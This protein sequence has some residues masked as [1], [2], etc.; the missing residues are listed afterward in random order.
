[1]KSVVRASV[2]L[3]LMSGLWSTAV[4]ARCN[5][6]SCKP[7]KP[8]GAQSCVNVADNCVPCDRGNVCG[9]NTCKS[10]CG[11]KLP[12]CIDLGG[13]NVRIRGGQIYAWQGFP[14]ACATP[15]QAA[16]VIEKLAPATVVVGD[17]FSY[18]VQITNRGKNALSS[19]A[20]TDVLPE[21]FVFQSVSPSVPVVDGKL[22]L[23][24]GELPGNSAQQFTVTGSA[25]VTGCLVF[26]GEAQATFAF[27]IALP[28]TVTQ[29]A[30]EV[31][32][33]A[34]DCIDLCDT[35]SAVVCVKNPGTAIT[36][37]NCVTVNLPAG[38]TTARGESQVVF[39]AG[40]LKPGESKSFNL[41]DLRASAG[42]DFALTATATNSRGLLAGSVAVVK[43][44]QPI[45]AVTKGATAKVFLDKKILYEITVTNVGD[46][47]AKDVVLCDAF[48][49]DSANV[50]LGDFNPR[51]TVA[52][53]GKNMTWNIGS[54]QPGESRVFQY[55]VTATE[56]GVVRNTATVVAYCA[57]PRM[58]VAHT[59]VEGLPGLNTCVTSD[60]DPASLGEVVTYTIETK[61][62]GR[63]PNTNLV[64]EVILD[65]GMEFVD[66]T[67]PRQTSYTTDGAR[68]I[69]FDAL[70]NLG[71]NQTERWTVRVKALT[72]GDKRFITR[73]STDQ[74]KKENGGSGLPLIVEAAGTFYDPTPVMASAQ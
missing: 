50:R 71:N 21:G 62:Q 26:A 66:A 57:E 59:P 60:N 28:V 33:T 12:K 37:E 10:D 70:P 29:P 18:T 65:E 58:A 42:G 11:V 55:N 52:R 45:L 51:A 67:G 19:V 47:V 61:N 69:V 41:R 48:D 46:T 8:C 36:Y 3:L 68:T 16:V 72:T 38:I 34:P 24:I 40:T 32:I 35:L 9:Q 43:V 31:L 13:P 4:W 44:R 25:S 73:L 20:V 27:P 22:A 7:A 14:A 6:P 17:E 49:A 53:N 1:M 63:V 30:L 64:Y 5:T 15:S 56:V 74:F 54:M 23:V 2:A 39:N